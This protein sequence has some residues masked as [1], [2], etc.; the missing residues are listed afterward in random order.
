MALKTPSAVQRKK[1]KLELTARRVRMRDVL[2]A[3]LAGHSS[4]LCAG[5]STNRASPSHFACHNII[6]CTRFHFLAFVD[7]KTAYVPT[8]KVFDYSKDRRS[9]WMERV[10]LKRRCTSNWAKSH[11]LAAL[12]VN[13]RRSARGN[14]YSRQQGPPVRW[15]S[16]D[17]YFSVFLV[18]CLASFILVTPV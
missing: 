5:G 16:N 17:L 1:K 13:F 12:L 18:I 2:T 8:S 7:K 9:Q 10:T 3:H 6:H 4:S 14:P 11:W 15:H